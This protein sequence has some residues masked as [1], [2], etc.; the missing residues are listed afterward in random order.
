[1]PLMNIVFGKVV[2]NFSMGEIDTSS[3]TPEDAARVLK[4]LT[5][6]T[7]KNTYV[8]LTTLLLLAST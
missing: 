5:D 4:Q 8:T 3:A 7:N 2:G 6:S 1:M